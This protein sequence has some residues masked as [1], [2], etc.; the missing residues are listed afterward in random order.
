MGLPLAKVHVMPGISMHTRTMA[1]IFS[2]VVMF[3][4]SSPGRV[5]IC[6]SQSEISCT[7]STMGGSGCP[8]M[9][10]V[11]LI[12]SI[13]ATSLGVSLVSM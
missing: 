3:L 12:F 9:V 13:S 1:A 7:T 8:R 5:G 10:A 6:C 11:L 2:L 4:V